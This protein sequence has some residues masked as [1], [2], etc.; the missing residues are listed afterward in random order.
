MSHPV[1]GLSGT[2]PSE[3]APA[4]SLALVTERP[5]PLEL[6]TRALGMGL[7]IGGLLAITNVYMGLKTGWWESGSV[8]A[9][10]LGFSALASV[11]RRRGAPYTPLENNLTQTAAAAVGAMP[12]AAGLLGALPAL[13]LLAPP[14][15]AGVWRCGAWRWGCWACSPRTCCGGGW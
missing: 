11:S 8:T 4:P 6:T 15:R 7:L 1:S 3:V 14:S 12:A 10:V 9:A 2:D 13:A 5:A